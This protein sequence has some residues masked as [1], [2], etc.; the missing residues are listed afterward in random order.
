VFL[1][2][3]TSAGST[4]HGLVAPNGGNAGFFSASPSFGSGVG[5]IAIANA[6]TLPSADPTSGV[7]AFSDSSVLKLRS[8][9]S[10]LSTLTGLLGLASSDGNVEVAIEVLTATTT[11]ATAT[12]MTRAGV[13]GATGIPI[14]SDSTVAFFA[15]VSARRTDVN[16]ESNAYQ[17]FYA[18]DNNAGT[19]AQIGTLSASLSLSAIMEEQAA[20]DVQF[21]PDNTNDK[22]QLQVTGAASKTIRWVAFVVVVRSKG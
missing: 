13:D 4:P 11:N 17:G 7:V 14:V 16:G 20:W 21:V 3:N 10:Y 12:Q 15:V 8:T 5:V 6:G 19:T 9:R 2:Q 22:L 18:V 1:A